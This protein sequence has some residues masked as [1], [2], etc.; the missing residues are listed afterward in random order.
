MCVFKISDV[1][2]LFNIIYLTNLI[3]YKCLLKGGGISCYYASFVIFEAV[4]R[5]RDLIFFVGAHI[6]IYY[7]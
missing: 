4:F 5:V 1:Q 6:N 7:M 2:N 3:L